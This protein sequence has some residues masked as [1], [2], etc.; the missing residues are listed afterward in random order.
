M[1]FCN[2]VLILCLAGYA[3]ADCMISY[4]GDPTR[5]N[6]YLDDA[7]TPIFPI[8]VTGIPPAQFTLERC[9]TECRKFSPT[10]SSFAVSGG[11]IPICLCGIHPNL[12]PTQTT[13]CNVKCGGNPDEICGGPDRLASVYSFVCSP[14]PAPP[15]VRPGHGGK[16]S[17]GFSDI[18]GAVF[19]FVFGVG[20]VSFAIT[21]VICVFILK[22]D[23]LPLRDHATAFVDLLGD[24]AAF[25]ISSVRGLR[26]HGDYDSA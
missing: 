16:S 22:K 26:R 14:G 17:F 25:V 9:A 6:C 1:R 23:G 10:T 24:G 18:L 3:H 5:E 4:F 12:P 20:I 19:L 15:P 7:T 21:T 13:G 2:T 8:K 11:L